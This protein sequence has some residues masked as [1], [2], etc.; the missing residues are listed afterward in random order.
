MCGGEKAQNMP[1]FVGTPSFNLCALILNR[2]QFRLQRQSGFAGG[3]IGA[4]LLPPATVRPPMIEEESHQQAPAVAAPPSQQRGN[5]GN[6]EDGAGGGAVEA[7]SGTGGGLGEQSLLVSDTSGYGPIVAAVAPP[8]NGARLHAKNQPPNVASQPQR[9]MFYER[10]LPMG[11]D[12]TS[13]HI[14]GTPGMAYD[15]PAIDGREFS[16]GA[17]GATPMATPNMMMPRHLMPASSSVAGPSAGMSPN[18]EFRSLLMAATAAA[19]ANAPKG[20]GNK[21]DSPGID[22]SS[23]TLS[24]AAGV[25]LTALTLMQNGHYPIRQTDHHHN[26]NDNDS[27][28]VAS[29]LPSIVPPIIAGTLSHQHHHHDIDG[30]GGVSLPGVVGY[31]APSSTNAIAPSITSSAAPLTSV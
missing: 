5:A 17:N 26:T 23:P 6:G 1:R 14:G 3:G 2:P 24:L 20:M 12:Q 15:D 10:M 16:A 7:N 8:T 31:S 19:A 29:P 21:N 18:N 30:D 22:L 28:P 27:T 9:P 13:Y 4:R 11:V 25:P